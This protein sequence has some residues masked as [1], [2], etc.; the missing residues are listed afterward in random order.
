MNINFH[1]FVIKT[2]C[3]AAGFEETDAQTIAYY[4]QQIDDFIMDRPICVEKEPPAYFA[5]NGYAYQITDKLWLMMPHPTGI[6]MLK[7]LGKNYR[8]TTLAAFHFIPAMPISQIDAKQCSR[9]AYR[10]IQGSRSEAALIRQIIADAVER[11]KLEGTERREASLMQLGMACHTYADTYAHCGFSG[12][13]G[14]ENRAV[15]EKV[16]N[17]STGREEISWAER[18]IFHKV[19]PI[20]HGNAGT[21]PDLCVCSIDLKM[22]SDKE[23]V[24]MSLHITRDNRQWFMQCARE[25]LNLFCDCLNKEHWEDEKWE[26]LKEQMFEVMQGPEIDKS[27]KD[28][29]YKKWRAAFQ[30]ITYSYE[31]NQRSFNKED[32]VANELGNCIIKHVTDAFFDYN[33]L[34]YKRVEQVTGTANFLT[35]WKEQIAESA[36]VMQGIEK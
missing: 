5:E 24:D 11:V 1:Y 2:L 31:K 14:W 30:D 27:R 12:L 23:D 4:S 22:Q 19:P 15:I 18:E 21:A 29:L 7:S 32:T 36:R 9:D 33:M 6:D 16:H 13:E 34:A 17:E 8:H 35:E 10:C 25:I 26:E 3:R 20:G 28:W